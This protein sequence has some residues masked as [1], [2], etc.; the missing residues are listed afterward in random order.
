MEEKINIFGKNQFEIGSLEENLVLRT[1]GRVYIRFGKKYI[2]LLDENGNLKVNVPK[3]ITKV[4]SEDKITGTGFYLYNGDLY[5]SYE[6]EVIQLTG[7]EGGNYI[8]YEGKQNLTQKQVLTAQQNIG[9]TFESTNDALKTISNG[10][11]FI[12]EKIYGIKEGKIKEI[13]LNPPLIGINNASLDEYPSKDN[14]TITWSKGKWQY[15][16]MVTLEEFSNYKKE[17]EEKEKE[18]EEDQEEE[19]NYLFD[20]IQ[21]SK[22]YTIK[23]GFDFELQQ[24]SETDYNTY[25]IRCDTLPEFNQDPND[26]LIL[27]V[28]G[29][30]GIHTKENGKDIVTPTTVQVRKTH[31]VPLKNFINDEGIIDEQAINAYAKGI[32]EGQPPLYP[33]A[34][35][36]IDATRN[37]VVI[38]RTENEIAETIYIFNLKY[39]DNKLYFINSEGDEISY[40]II[41]INYQGQRLVVLDINK[42]GED[43]YE[44]IAFEYSENSFNGKHLYVK[45]EQLKKEKFKIDYYNAEISIEENYPTSSGNPQIN[46]HVV[47][48]DISSFRTYSDK[49]FSQGIYSDQAVFNGTEFKESNESNIETK[50]CPRYSIKLNN[51]LCASSE[52]PEN[53]DEVIPSIKFIRDIIGKNY[54]ISAEYISS[55]KK[56]YLYKKDGLVAAEIDATDFIKDGMVSNV[57]VVDNNIVITFNTDSGKEDISIPISR[58][59]DASKY[60][61][62]EETYNKEEID[63][64][65]VESSSSS[66]PIGTILMWPGSSLPDG[67]LICDGSNFNREDYPKL[68]EILNSTRLPDLRN[69]FIVGAGDEYNL[70]ATGGEKTHTLTTGELPKHSHSV[71]DYY[72]IED[73]GHIQGLSGKDTLPNGYHGSGA[74]DSDNHYLYYKT[75]DTK[76][77]GNNEGHENRPPYYALYYIIKASNSTSN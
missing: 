5:I 33:D 63:S 20:P 64:M 16:P 55:D 34:V 57:E 17:Q 50:D 58:I 68:Y 11:V 21:Y 52:I 23:N 14:S 44:S 61:T 18:E 70:K 29:F 59:F 32:I 1:K 40:P 22:V 28:N 37:V 60:Y 8:Q 49:E 51:L 48:G 19:A 69:R 10:V 15:V 12:G 75:H 25:A 27:S 9:L 38:V 35:W 6:N 42:I 74:S 46:P 31:E 62:K 66:T 45:A 3:V 4:D 2:E 24:A 76:E 41:K 54:I 71:N 56:I 26:I 72:Y 53:Y 47:L 30:F 36:S 7:T 13:P 77:T 65:I 67:Y 43:E 73:H 39:K